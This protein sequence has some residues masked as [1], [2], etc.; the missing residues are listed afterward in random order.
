MAGKASC[1]A[2]EKDFVGFL[3][4]LS[5]ETRSFALVEV[6]IN[7]TCLEVLLGVEDSVVGGLWPPST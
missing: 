3:A 5:P 7:P 4:V 1:E 2:V 6:A